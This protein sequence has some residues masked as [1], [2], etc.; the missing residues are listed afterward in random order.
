MT[1]SVIKRKSISTAGNSRGL[2][3]TSRYLAWLLYHTIHESQDEGMTVLP[4]VSIFC[5]GEELRYFIEG[6]EHVRRETGRQIREG[7]TDI[8][9]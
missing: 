5:N 7:E 2:T 6:R 3:S 4:H 9:L 1:Q 8:E